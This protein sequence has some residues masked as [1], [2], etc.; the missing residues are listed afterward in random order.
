VRPDRD[1][2][3]DA[4][5]PVSLRDNAALRDESL[6]KDPDL[7]GGDRVVRL[8]VRHGGERG[9]WVVAVASGRWQPPAFSLLTDRR[10]WVRKHDQVRR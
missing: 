6:P 4:T 9:I 5:L 1:G 2:E 8:A 7:V 3:E 10:I